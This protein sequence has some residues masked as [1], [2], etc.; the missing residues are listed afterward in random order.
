MAVYVHAGGWAESGSCGV[1]YQYVGFEVAGG[2]IPLSEIGSPT[3]TVA[4][5][6]FPPI[7]T[8]TY[9]ASGTLTLHRVDTRLKGDEL[10]APQATLFDSKVWEATLH[11]PSATAKS[12]TWEM[13]PSSASDG[14]R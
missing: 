10:A 13:K 4:L 6:G 1:P 12:Y 2:S 3:I 7:G 11:N 5:T 14:P 9:T 8:K